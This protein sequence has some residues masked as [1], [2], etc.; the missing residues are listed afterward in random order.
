MFCFIYRRF[1]SFGFVLTTL[2]LFVAFLVITDTAISRPVLPDNE[3][4]DRTATCLTSIEEGLQRISSTA[5]GRPAVGG[6]Y[7]FWEDIRNNSAAIYGCNLRT[8]EEFLVK[9]IRKVTYVYN[10]TSDGQTLAWIARSPEGSH[11][12]GYNITTKQRFMIMAPTH[13]QAIDSAVLV[14]GVLYYA[15]HA[16]GGGGIYAIQ[17]ATGEK[18]QISPEGYGLVA[19]NSTLLWT[20]H[21]VLDRVVQEKSLH[22]R[23]MD[24]GQETVVVTF[25]GNAYFTG[26]DASHDTVIWSLFPGRDP[27][28]YMRDLSRSISTTTLLDPSGFGAYPVMHGNMVAWLAASPTGDLKK[29]AIKTYNLDTGE[30]SIVLREGSSLRT[31]DLLE[32]NRLV[33]TSENSL[34]SKSAL[35]IGDLSQLDVTSLGHPDTNATDIPDGQNEGT[36]FGGQVF[37]AGRHLSIQT[38]P[39]KTQRWPVHG[40]QF[41]LPDY[42]IDGETFTDDALA[43]TGPIT[44][45]GDSSRA[46]WLQKTEDR[47]HTQALRIFVPMPGERH[48]EHGNR[49]TPQNIYDFAQ[50]ARTHNMRLGVVIHNSPDFE[51][52]SEK[53]QWL[54]ELIQV[55]KGNNATNLIAY[56]NA[57]NEI[58]NHCDE[59][60]QDCYHIK[61]DTTYGFK[62]NAWVK[63]VANIVNDEDPGILVTV[64][65][66]TEL[67]NTVQVAVNNYLLA[68]SDGTSTITLT[69]VVDFIAPHNYGGGAFGVWEHAE[70]GYSGPVVLEEYGYPTDPFVAG[71]EPSEFRLE[72]P[73]ECRIDPW[74]L[75]EDGTGYTTQNCDR[76][77][78][79]FVETSARALG[80]DPRTDYAGGAAFMLVDT[81]ATAR[82]NFD[83][84]DDCSNLEA[85]ADYFTGLFAIGQEDDE[86]YCEPGGT[87]TRGFG[88][89]KFTGFRVCMYHTDYRLTECEPPLYLP[90]IRKESFE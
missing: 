61:W 11:I 1:R 89:L 79:G 66:S 37:V 5:F 59:S 6:D 26:Y 82:D 22:M 4:P 67:T 15:N 3:P 27:R 62:A 14:D 50:E 74:V 9:D 86:N 8:G 33:F 24:T 69:D 81:K 84:P 7:I 42:E 65:M 53:E 20:E 64:G 52:T 47:L 17:I 43:A 18:H 49:V 35:Y 2:S 32:G 13:R 70:A 40:V 71:S 10:L 85:T 76:T 56:I 41:I 16:S 23:N 38:D 80:A 88:D 45:G 87:Q 28:V 68:Q 19:S 73:P 31:R 34:T 30:I 48:N 36:A 60:Y 29:G 57:D 51:M 39:G 46:F 78:T 83:F 77:A 25:D 75:N 21:Q 58:N 90:L 55:F 72:G 63:S 54:R 44:Q 12:Q